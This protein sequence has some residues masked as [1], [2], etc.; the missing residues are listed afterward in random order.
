ML[1]ALGYTGRQVRASF[2]L[3]VTATILLGAA[4]GLACAVVVTYG[5]WFA[6]VKDLNDPYVIPWQ[7]IGVLVLVS[8]AVAMLATWV[9]IGRSAKVAPAEALR[10]LE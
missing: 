7:E 10:S 5:L 3:E 4:V 1:R 8:Y 6:I 9:P 2:F